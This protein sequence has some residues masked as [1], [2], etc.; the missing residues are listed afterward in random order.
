MK[1]LSFDNCQ[2]VSG[3]DSAA[4]VTANVPTENTGAF[5]NLLGLLFSN[6][7]NA[8]TLAAFLDNDAANF[9]QM[10]VEKITYGDFVI[11]RA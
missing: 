10:P 1:E 11:T 9:N 7:L 8:T 4:T 6:Q 3:G 5:V 2:H